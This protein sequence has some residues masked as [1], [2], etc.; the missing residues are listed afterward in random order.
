[1]GRLSAAVQQH[2]R[3]RYCNISSTPHIYINMFS[4]CITIRVCDN[5]SQRSD[6]I[7]AGSAAP[8]TPS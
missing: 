5:F 2:Q 4:T 7:L 6:C 8:G 1:M 3:G